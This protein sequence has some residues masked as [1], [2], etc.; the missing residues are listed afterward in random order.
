MAN[1]A[2]N[3]TASITIDKKDLTAQILKGLADGQKEVDK[4]RLTLFFDIDDEKTY[5]K[6]QKILKNFRKELVSADMKI[7]IDDTD[8]QESFKS[9]EGF[10]K[11]V[12]K[13]I[14]GHNLKL[15]VAINAEQQEKE[16]SALKRQI[17]QLS[18]ACLAY[19]RMVDELNAKLGK[20]GGKGGFGGDLEQFNEM[21]KS[22]SQLEQHVSKISK[23][24]S[25]VGDGQEFSPLLSTIDKI[26]AAVN[27]LK[28]STQN[29]K[30]NMNV[31]MGSN[32][33]LD[34]KFQAKVAA[35]LNAYM[36][37]FDQIKMSGAGGSVINQKFFDFDINQFDTAYS[38][39]QGLKKFID[40]MREEAKKQYN[41][42]DVLKED[43]DLSYWNKASAAIAQVT[44]VMNEAKN[45][46][47]AGQIDQLFGKTDL[48]GVAS[49]LDVIV[50]KLSEITSIAGEFSD[51]FKNGFNVNASVEEITT[52]TKRVEELEAELAKVKMPTIKEA[53]ATNTATTSSGNFL[54]FGKIPNN[55]QSINWLKVSEYEDEEIRNLEQ[56]GYG[57]QAAVDTIIGARD[58]L[59]EKG[60]SVFKLG[61]DNLPVIENVKQLLDLLNRL[62]SE[63]AL[64]V[65]GD[66]VGSGTDDEPLIKNI[67]QLS[68][69]VV[70]K[71]QLYQK[72]EETILKYYD[73]EQDV[74]TSSIGANDYKAIFNGKVYRRKPQTDSSEQQEKIRSE[75][76]ETEVQAK[77]TTQAI[78]EVSTATSST[79]SMK[80]AFQDKNAVANTA[81]IKENLD[82]VAGSE[83]KVADQFRDIQRVIEK[84]INT[85]KD[86][87]R[88]LS[89]TGEFNLDKRVSAIYQKNDGQLVSRTYE[90]NTDKDGNFLYKKDGNVDYKVS[91]TV[92]SK[93]EQLEK[94]IIKAD[95]ELR[96]LRKDLA[97]V[98]ETNPDASTANIE[99]KIQ[100]Q[101]EYI[102]LLNQTAKEISKS[103]E[104]FITEKQII[105]ARAKAANEYKMDQG[106]KQD[107]ANAK[108]LAKEEQ[109]TQQAVTATNRALAKQQIAVDKI[110][111][112]YSKAANPDLDKHVSNQDDLQM[113]AAKKAEIQELINKLTNQP[114][115][116]SNESEFLHLEKLIADYK[117]LADAKFK[118]NNPSKQNMDT[119][120]L[121]VTVAQ[122]VSEYNKLIQ[123]S[124]KYGVLTEHITEELKRQRDVI[125]EKDANGVYTAKQGVT[126]E[127]YK[128]AR[129]LFKLKKA[130]VT[131][132]AAQYNGQNTQE[133]AEIDSLTSMLNRYA[134]MQSR[135]TKGKMFDNDIES[136]KELRKEIEKAINSGNLAE[137][138]IAEASDRLKEID[139]RTKDT[140]FA[141]A[142]SYLQTK[143]NQLTK[144]KNSP[145]GYK[146]NDTY[147]GY[148]KQY[149]EQLNIIQSIVDK[150]NSTPINNMTDKELSDLQTA[151]QELASIEKS[152]NSMTTGQ[153]GSSDTAVNKLKGMVAEVNS[154]TRMTRESRAEFD[155]MVAGWSKNN[156][157]NVNT[158]EAIGQ[159]KE[160]KGRLI[161]TGQ[162]GK[163]FLD[164]I[165][166]KAWYSW[167]AQLGT[168]FNLW[169]VINGIKRG[170]ESVKE[171]NTAL[172]EMRKVSEESE[173]SLRNYQQTTFNTANEIGSTALQLQQST[174]D[175][176][177]LGES[178]DQAAESAKDA[179]ILYN[180]S[181]FG[182]ID[183]ATE[184]LV[185]MSQAYK[186]LDK[187]DII[188]VL[189]NIGNRYSISTD[190]LA[191]ALKDSASALVTANNDLNSAVA[192]TT[193]GNAITQDPS[194]VGAGLR[195]I[196]LRLV[197]TEAAKKQLSD[198]GEETDGMITSVSK[199]RDKILDATK[200]ASKDG[201]GF[202]ILDSNGNYKSTYE[203]MQGLSDLYDDIV[204]KDKELGTNNLN[205][206]L[207]TIAG[208]FLPE[209]YRN[210]FYRTYLI[211]RAASIG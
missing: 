21:S 75:L 81:E 96:N 42:H 169:S 27:E 113:L 17:E 33:E 34:A 154:F 146:H 36:R 144:Y 188:D 194:K 38:K 60:V 138:R 187:I 74:E 202:D 200:A 82:A 28:S 65:S 181:E 76:K 176:M 99:A 95:D 142:G 47:G 124:E 97:T 77:N 105:Q 111:K 143:Q 168:M 89:Q 40:S 114:R 29:I 35:A 68:E 56:Q 134:E 83:E 13:L 78:D 131:S 139:K 15:N 109:K 159:L 185:S 204:K 73:Y 118:A 106:V 50:E 91:E 158:Q 148:L 195:T 86:Y 123:Q 49:Q 31:E 9:V 209:R 16:I 170:V 71:K 136:A 121:D 11:N 151:K 129:D 98:K 43:T 3:M 182:S 6:F 162:A 48:T 189:N 19:S 41:G 173:Q 150:V 64:L 88:V 122:M 4:N 128:T 160:F 66:V 117:L 167:A 186:D 112:S 51:V 69:Y 104:Y 211:A 67:N 59:Y 207:E 153:K 94:I 166:D 126:S 5:E 14:K 125:A 163:G 203:I 24:F 70:D 208:E 58:G 100:A 25:D 110:E 175:W 84:T 72:L 52:L 90:A 120:N 46:T 37:L 177:R 152:L 101:K 102:K 132:Y 116:Q 39:L 155:K 107:V 171:L 184:S 80:D 183:E 199:L 172:T 61:S 198:L 141:N 133:E 62:Q 12:E 85:S 87:A 147:L 206:L 8:V 161:E 103:D 55:E 23:V 53:S 54:R 22:L 26:T 165:K 7:R 196:S 32:S 145:K 93:Y 135:I 179:T 10:I 30:L 140:S 164:T 137:D 193:A 174:A 180:V 20:T 205:L 156:W 210:I 130:T 18:D 63:E 57:I 1:V 44:K 79:G 178:M 191:T 119:K 157:K 201:K 197:G 115:N 149:R 190:G 192:L 92:I 108:Q 127:Q 2:A 45:S